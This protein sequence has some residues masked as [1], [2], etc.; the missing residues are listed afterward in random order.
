MIASR[1][2]RGFLTPIR[3]LRHSPG[4]LLLL[5]V[6]ALTA[7]TT[8]WTTDQD[9]EE[10]ELS[11]RA[12]PRVGFVPA[13]ILFIGELR[14]GSDNHQPLYELPYLLQCQLVRLYSPHELYQLYLN[15]FYLWLI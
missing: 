13:E 2:T 1:L 11:L 9:T 14:G 10:P 6:V 12:T 7:P 3:G 5:I 15:D 4:L 8:G